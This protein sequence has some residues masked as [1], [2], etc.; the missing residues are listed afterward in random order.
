MRLSEQTG[1]SRPLQERLEA[2][3]LRL[4]LVRAL[5]GVSWSA[6][7]AAVA[8]G[9]L[10]LVGLVGARWAAVD[11][12]SAGVA[13][14][15]AGG[16]L[17][18]GLAA[19]AVRVG[20]SRTSLLAVARRADRRF[21]LD[22][23]LS[24]AVEFGMLEG[25]D[26][27]RPAPPS[28]VLSA[29]YRDV[30]ERAVRV[31]PEAL[32]PFTTPRATRYLVAVALAVLAFEIAVPRPGAG[33]GAP[34]ST[35][36]EIAEDRAATVDFLL[37]TAALL[38]READARSNDYLRV[39]ATALES[40]ALDIVEDRLSGEAMGEA[41]ARLAAHAELALRSGDV[42]PGGEA[43]S[44]TGAGTDGMAWE[45]G[46]NQVGSSGD[47]DP[48]APPS[49]SGAMAQAGSMLSEARSALEGV[50]SRLE[51]DSADGERLAGDPSSPSSGEGAMSEF[52]PSQLSGR[53]AEVTDGER[54]LANLSLDGQAP[55]EG[56]FGEGGSLQEGV[57]SG[58]LAGTPDRTALPDASSAR[59]FELPSEGGSRRR[60]PIEIVPDT[61]FSSVDEVPLARGNWRPGTEPRVSSDFLGL[62]HREIAS[63]YFLSLTEE[64]P[65]EAP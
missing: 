2:S 30:A 26:G 43:G 59:D 1:T 65:P 46:E 62:S 57:G 14:A 29:L 22:E 19:T 21:G 25:A 24:T 28:P 36:A 17:L 35:Q 8:F 42:Q 3:R 10:R 15:A 16:V 63:R 9:G 7:A 54:A 50:R 47:R 52:D 23:R 12:L 51:G 49:G 6:L 60:L 18:A 39:V 44:T 45:E 53:S 55:P 56:G 48:E 41:L 4:D 13:W 5:E 37:E 20:R 58:I 64:P 38:R 32:V 40:L 11:F 61:R 31:T 34:R 33:P 27:S